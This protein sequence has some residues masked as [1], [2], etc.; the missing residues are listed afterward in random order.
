MLTIL[1]QIKHRYIFNVLDFDNNGYI[2]KA[3]FIAIAE[4]L[5]MVRG[6]ETDTEEKRALDHYQKQPYNVWVYFQ[7]RSC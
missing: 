3:D 5:C 4:N 7:K 2:E 6:E 1:Q